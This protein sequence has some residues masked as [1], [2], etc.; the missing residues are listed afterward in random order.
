MQFIRLYKSLSR[1]ERILWLGSVIA[2]TA[3]F[4]LP[5]SRDYLTLIA[6]LIG[7]TALIFVAKGHVLGQLLTVVFSLFY[8]VISYFFCYYGEM[9]TY[10]GMTAPIAVAAMLS[11]M[12][13]PYQASAE[14]AVS[15]VTQKQLLFLSAA[16]AAV[17]AAFYFILQAL[18][19]PNLFFSTV[20]IATS[21]LAASLTL[22]R[23][24]W[25]AAA[26]MANDMVLVILWVLASRADSAY[27]PM[28]ACFSVFF[29]NDLYGLVNWRRMKQRQSTLH[30]DGQAA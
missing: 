26:Y 13:H 27:F 10:L 14:V 9:I 19:T 17:T 18:D 24:P 28:V 4:L 25:Y 23:S 8:G 7:V 22:L 21:F 29:V 6:S 11:W 12:K 1:F 16:A 15:H 30:E 3:A 2:V 5:A 20:S